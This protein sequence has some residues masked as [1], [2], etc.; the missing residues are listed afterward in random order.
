MRHY[1]EAG[2]MI[3][4]Q[5]DG[6]SESFTRFVEQFAKKLFPQYEFQDVPPS[7]PIYSVD[8]DLKGNPPL[9]MVTNGSR[10]LLLHSPKDISRYWETRDDKLHKRFF[11]LGL[12]I[13]LYAGGKNDLR[14]KLETTYVPEPPPLPKGAMTIKMLRLMYNGNWDPE[15]GAWERYRRG[16][17]NATGTGLNVEAIQLKDLRPGMAP[18]AHLTG[19][20][21]YELTSDETTAL[22]DFVE[23]GGVVLIDAC[24]GSGPFADSMRKSLA[25][26]FDLAPLTRIPPSHPLLQPGPPGMADLSKPLF[27]Q[28]VLDKTGPR[29]AGGLEILSAK[30]GHVIFS[31][32]DLSSGLLGTNT[33]GIWGYAPNYSQSFMQNLIFWTVDGQRENAPAAQ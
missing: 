18:V 28:F 13:S 20:A 7:H 12:N 9:K 29:F 2:G 14:N 22:R 10:I 3:F 5:A 26:A 23:Q 17:Q 16:F 21:K 11:Q 19:T 1:V 25:G 27:R 15:P 33:W 30:K 31:P 8:Y 24:G 32:L 4:T 6:D